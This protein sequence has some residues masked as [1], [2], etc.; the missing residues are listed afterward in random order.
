MFNPE[1]PASP[2]GP[3][4]TASW[5]ILR[6]RQLRSTS[7]ASVPVP[8]WP[9]LEEVD[10]GVP[11]TTTGGTKVVVS[12]QKCP[13]WWHRPSGGSE[14]PQRL[15]AV[16]ESWRDLPWPQWPCEKRFGENLIVNFPAAHIKVG[17]GA[18]VWR[19]MRFFCVLLFCVILCMLCF[20]C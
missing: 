18:W 7:L 10:K 1:P 4:I 6:P 13:C 14:Y 16:R 17:N 19:V 12:D 11:D 20:L 3:A 15:L 5:N 9:V 2:E 8:Q